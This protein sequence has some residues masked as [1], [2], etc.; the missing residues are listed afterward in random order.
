MNRYQLE[1]MKSGIVAELKAATE[2]LNSLYTNTASTVEDRNT[3]KNVVI[4]MKERL[5]GVNS[6]IK[7]MDDAAS[8]KLSGMG[9]SSDPKEGMINAKA[10][11]YRANMQNRPI[12]NE[13]KAALIDT[14]TSGGDKFLPKTVANEILT[15]PTVKN[16]LRG[17]STYTTI[18]NLE[19]PKISFSLD[20]DDFIEDG[21]TAKEL[22][23][24][25][26]NVTFGRNKFKIFADISETIIAGTNTNLVSTVDIAL[27]SGLAKKEK[28]V[29]FSVNP[30]DTNKHMSF[31]AGTT[32]GGTTTYEI[33]TVKGLTK[34]KAIKAAI[35]DLE[36]EYREN[37]KVCMTY[38]DY[39]DII[40]DLANGNASLY[41]AQ[42]EQ[43]LGKAA[44]FCDDAKIPIVGDF[45]FSHFNYDIGMI[46]DH[47]KN[48][49]T[50]MESFV[51]TAWFDHQIKLKSAFRLAIV[52][53]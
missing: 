45:S 1:T 35:A 3:Q 33:V 37:A 15:E 28:K 40:E 5:E 44:F 36:E 7:E 6:Q 4:D 16:P 49:K 27:E 43:I 42:P 32:E 18:P 47:D 8:S 38:A 30:T 26:S 25:G 2:K 21:A 14:S 24:A 20:D 13:F 10:E 41:A 23:V 22:K 19:I 48:V 12:A 17:Y 51:L 11:L 39:L 46:Y 52:S 50:G 34:L 31:Y 9:N 29:A 53:V